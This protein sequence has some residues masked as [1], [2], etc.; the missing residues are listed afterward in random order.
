MEPTRNNP[1]VA[2]ENGAIESAHGHIKAA[3]RDAL[4][5]RGSADFSDLADYRRFIDEVV[6]ARN[7]RHGPGID[8]ERRFLQPLPDV[9]TTDYEEI[10]VTV[11]S[12]GGFT[13]RKVFYTV[14]SR[15]IGHRLRARLYDGHLDLDPAIKVRL[16]QMSPATIDRVLRIAKGNNQKDRRR[17][18]AGSE[19]RRSVPI[20][21][22]SDWG[23]PA[24]GHMEADLVSHSGPVAKG[25]WA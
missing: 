1:G 14:P 3:I 21:T 10:L 7:R 23:D 12:S 4:L 17:G 5:L 6:N 2:H 13:L 25:S 18:V 11:T 16:L 9:R 15:L 22:F 24:P 8:A 20:R 19:L